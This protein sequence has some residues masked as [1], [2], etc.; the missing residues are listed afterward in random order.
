MKIK[1]KIITKYGKFES[2]ILSVTEEEYL[3]W[4]NLMQDC[5]NLAYLCLAND[6]TKFFF[7]KEI[8]KDSIISIEIADR[9]A[10]S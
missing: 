10:T 8:I 6:D 2:G 5:S 1:I 3:A 7:P 9:Y 4:D